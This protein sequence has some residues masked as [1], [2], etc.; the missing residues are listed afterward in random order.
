VPIQ[1]NPKMQFI[2]HFFQ[3]V[4]TIVNQKSKI[5]ALVVALWWCIQITRL[6][7]SKKY[8]SRGISCL[9]YTI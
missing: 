1:K 4:I 7:A 6:R 5:E 9:Y 3:L 2:E 8:F